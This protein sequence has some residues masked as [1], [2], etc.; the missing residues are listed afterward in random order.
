LIE[1]S[2]AELLIV[3]ESS[4]EGHALNESAAIVFDLSDGATSRAVMVSE[5]ARRT[6]LPSGAPG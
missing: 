1:R 3:K 4:Q 5:M 2:E 6:G